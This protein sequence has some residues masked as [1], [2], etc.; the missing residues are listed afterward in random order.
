M[1]LHLPE[2]AFNDEQACAADS[3]FSLGGQLELLGAAQI[4]HE[5]PVSVRGGHHYHSPCCA[6]WA[7]A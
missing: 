3:C 5:C 4:G 6:T 1:Y 7:G 2:V